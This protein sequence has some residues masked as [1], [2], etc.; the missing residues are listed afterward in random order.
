MKSK[1]E[2]AIWCDTLDPF[3]ER[4]P[5]VKRVNLL[6]FPKHSKDSESLETYK[7]KTL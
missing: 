4:R 2:T 7:V 3:G 6:I 1:T 5:G